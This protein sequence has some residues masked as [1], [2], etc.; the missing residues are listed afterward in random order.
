MKTGRSACCGRNSGGDAYR[1]TILVLLAFTPAFVQAQPT[2]PSEAIE[3]FED[4]IGDRVEAVTILGGDYG[5][6]GGV[7]PFRGGTLA[8]PSIA[9]IGV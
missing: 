5:A 9:K 1:Y 2:L 6:A 4:V 7:S 8:N 3:Q